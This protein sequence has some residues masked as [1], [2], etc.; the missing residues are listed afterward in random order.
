MNN[1]SIFQGNGQSYRI[2]QSSYAGPYHPDN[3]WFYELYD[4]NIFSWEK[5]PRESLYMSTLSINADP[6]RG[7]KYLGCFLIVLGTAWFVYRKKEQTPT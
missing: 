5:T 3:P 2:Y 7:L 1:P 4:G 6:G